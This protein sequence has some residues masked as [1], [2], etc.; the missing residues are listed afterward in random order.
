MKIQLPKGCV[1]LVGQ[2][3][4][5][6]QVGGHSNLYH[7]LLYPTLNGFLKVRSRAAQVPYDILATNRKEGGFLSCRGASLSLRKS[8]RA[9]GPI[10]PPTLSLSRKVAPSIVGKADM[11]GGCGI[12][13]GREE[14]DFYLRFF[15]SKVTTWAPDSYQFANANL[16]VSS[17]HAPPPPPWPHGHVSLPNRSSGIGKYQF[18]TFSSPISPCCLT[19]HETVT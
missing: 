8:E 13:K 14:R 2:M 12:L 7:G 1:C 15:S 11:Q 18:K 10:G 17:T 6:I 16:Q 9:L 3:I 5:M 19:L 4:T